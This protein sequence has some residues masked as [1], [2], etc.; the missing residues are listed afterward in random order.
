MNAKFLGRVHA[1]SF[2]ASL[3]GKMRDAGSEV[4]VHGALNCREL[5]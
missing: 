1:T 4:G 5:V 3:I 2:P